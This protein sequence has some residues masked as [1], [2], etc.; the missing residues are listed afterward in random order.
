MTT[1]IANWYVLGDK[2][3]WWTMLQGNVIPKGTPSGAQIST[4]H[5][6]AGKA[7]KFIGSSIK[8]AQYARYNDGMWMITGTD[9]KRYIAAYPTHYANRNYPEQCVRDDQELEAQL[10]RAISVPAKP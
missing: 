9:G 7:G 8:I 2:L 5:D 3:Y 1:V 4:G 10:V 6:F